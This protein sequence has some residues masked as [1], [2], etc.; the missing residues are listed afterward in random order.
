MPNQMS[1]LN[2]KENLLILLYNSEIKNHKEILAYTKSAEKECHTVD[3]SKTKVTG[4]VWAEVAEKLSITV[5]GLIDTDHSSFENRYG[6]EKELSADDTIKILQNDPE[7]LIFPILIK[8]D[9]AQVI[10]NYSE[11]TR[12]HDADSIGIDKTEIGKENKY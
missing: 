2:T 1:V 7:M 9:N 5:H 6:K 11:V 4:T 3:I 10:K 12:F 8:G